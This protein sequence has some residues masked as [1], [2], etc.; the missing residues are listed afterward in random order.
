MKVTDET[1]KV[2]EVPKKIP[3]MQRDTNWDADV[4]EQGIQEIGYS[5]R[6]KSMYDNTGHG[7][8]FK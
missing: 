1:V 4:K 7:C 8:R 5:Q 6:N 2:N 3:V